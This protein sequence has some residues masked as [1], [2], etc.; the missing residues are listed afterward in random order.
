MSDGGPKGNIPSGVKRFQMVTESDARTIEYGSTIV[1]V[2]G[3]HITPLALD[4]LRERR[5]SV[6]RDSADQDAAALAPTAAIRTVAIAG[7]HT[8][9]ALKARLVQHLRGRGIAAH[10]LGTGTSEPVDYPDTAAAAA[11]QVVRGEADAADRK[12]VV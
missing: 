10:D 4:T 5:V 1:L 11:T 12:S 2:A 7:D 8:S 3:G 6:V 9:L